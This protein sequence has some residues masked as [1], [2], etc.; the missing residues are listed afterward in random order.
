M[1]GSIRTAV[2]NYT[3]SQRPCSIRWGDWRSFNEVAD[4]HVN[5]PVIQWLGRTSSRSS[6]HGHCRS[7]GLKFNWQSSVAHSIACVAKV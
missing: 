2:F 5:L 7:S 3:C 6:R 4:S 1:T